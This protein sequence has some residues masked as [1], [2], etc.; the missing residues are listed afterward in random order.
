MKRNSLVE[1]IGGQC[2]Y[3][4]TV[5]PLEEETPYVVSDVYI[6]DKLNKAVLQ[7]NEAGETAFIV[8]MFREIQPPMDLTE[9]IE[10]T[11]FLPDHSIKMQTN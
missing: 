1:Y 11:K 8:E 6:S 2:E 4:K 7:L 10:E 3:G 9:L 5:F